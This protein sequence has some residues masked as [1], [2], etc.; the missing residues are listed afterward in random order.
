MSVES[1]D[2]II[3]FVKLGYDGHSLGA[4]HQSQRVHMLSRLKVSLVKVRLFSGLFGVLVTLLVFNFPPHLA[5]IKSYFSVLFLIL[6][7]FYVS[8]SNQV[9][10][11]RHLLE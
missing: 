9:F 5:I 11:Y 7:E 8:I 1:E 4:C 3:L 6:V 2:E 10:S